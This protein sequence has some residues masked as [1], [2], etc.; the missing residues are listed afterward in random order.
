MYLGP[1]GHQNHVLKHLLGS[2][3]CTV[4]P[5]WLVNLAL[6]YP[7]GDKKT[8]QKLNFPLRSQNTF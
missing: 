2:Q 3:T 7:L 8:K 4:V 6:K 5:Y 1:L